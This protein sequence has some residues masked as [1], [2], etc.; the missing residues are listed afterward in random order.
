LE[1]VL[2]DSIPYLIKYQLAVLILFL[3]SSGAIGQEVQTDSFRIKEASFAL[4]QPLPAGHYSSA[5][6]LI[7]VV[8]PTDWTIDNIKAPMFFYQGKYTLP[9]GFNLQAG[10]QTLL[11]SNRLHLGPYWNYR[12]GNDYLGL[13]WNVVWNYGRL[14]EFG[15]ATTLTG[16]EQQPS[17]AYGHC[18]EHTAVILR[19]DLYWTNALYLKEGENTI[20]SSNGFINGYS[21]SATFDQKLYKQKALSLGFKMNYLRYHIIAWPAFPVN[22]RRYWFPEFQIGLNLLKKKK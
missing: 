10:L 7:Y 2:A 17:I 21:F 12:S 9:R 6:A 1:I 22:A 16:W 20:P 19:A 18:F 13:G 11:I 3:L 15:F 8:T 14:N 4:P 5:I